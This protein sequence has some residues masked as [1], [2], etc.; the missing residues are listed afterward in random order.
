VTDQRTAEQ[1][2]EDERNG[3]ARFL[4]RDADLTITVTPSCQYCSK[5]G[6]EVTGPFSRRFDLGLDWLDRHLNGC[7]KARAAGRR[8]RT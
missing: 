7:V 1:R 4:N 8:V 3:G 6:P 2:A 5:E